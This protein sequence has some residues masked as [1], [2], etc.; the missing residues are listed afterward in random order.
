MCVSIISL[1][2]LSL[3]LIGKRNKEATSDKEDPVARIEAVCKRYVRDPF[4]VESGSLRNHVA[5]LNKFSFFSPLGSRGELFALCSVQKVASNSWGKFITEA[6][7][8]EAAALNRSNEDF[9]LRTLVNADCWPNCGRNMTKIIPVRHPFKRVLSAWRHIFDRDKRK[10]GL[11]ETIPWPDFVDLVSGLKE[12]TPKWSR[13]QRDIGSHWEP[14]WR[15]CSVCHEHLGPPKIWVVKM[16]NLPHDLE[17]LL[18]LVIEYN[19]VY[20]TVVWRLK[21][22]SQV[23]IHF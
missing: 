19:I 9:E 17:Q 4:R 1:S 21:A 10:Y 5:D 12:A 2:L 18:L 20:S 6:L 7:L 23:H 13:I 8:R 11:T 16:E 14:F 22:I 15:A 3:G